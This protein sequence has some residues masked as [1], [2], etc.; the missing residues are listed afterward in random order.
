MDNKYILGIDTSNYTSS[1]ALTDM[2]G[3]I[4]SDKRILLKVPIGKR[5]LR[6]QEA[7]FQHIKN[8]PLLLHDVLTDDDSEDTVNEKISGIAVSASPRP[9]P[10]SYMPVFEVGV[11]AAE[12]IGMS[13]GVEVMTF[14]HQEGHIR[15]GMAKS[16][17]LYCRHFTA[18]H[19]SGGTS[20]MLACSENTIKKLGGSLDISLGQLVDRLGV[21]AGLAFPAG[22]EMDRLAYEYF[23]QKGNQYQNILPPIKSNG[24]TFNLSGLETASIMSLEKR[25]DILPELS[26]MIFERLA[27]LLADLIRA[28]YDEGEKDFLL[29]GGVSSS[30]T[31]RRLLESK[32]EPVCRLYFADHGLGG[33]NAVG[34]SLLGGDRTWRYSL[35]Q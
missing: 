5:G 1:V 35:L 6:Q 3:N 24:R 19:L 25:K 31:L 26:F 28:R 29:V 27:N 7:V 11:S 12:L 2:A 4:I 15:A 9:I 34:I 20:E 32:I 18:F 13:L 17:L 21:K 10:G 22:A 16:P 30:R 23:E 14:S 33:D 8:L